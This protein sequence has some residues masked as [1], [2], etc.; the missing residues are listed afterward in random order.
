[1]NQEAQTR[2][3]VDMDGVLARFHDDILDENNVVQIEKMYEPN[4]FYQLKPFQKMVE[5][6]NHV[7]QY[8][9]NNIYILS[10]VD[11][12]HPDF[13]VQKTKWLQKYIP[14]LQ[15]S[16]FLFPDVKVDKCDFVKAMSS[17]HVLRKND[18]LIDDF[19][20]N[21]KSWH[22]AG[23]YSIKFKNNINH[24]G[25]GRFGGDKGEIWSGHIVYYDSPYL[26]DDI[27]VLLSSFFFE[28]FPYDPAYGFNLPDDEVMKIDTE[29]ENRMTAFAKTVN[30]IINRYGS[31]SISLDD[32]HCH[33]VV[34]KNL[35]FPDRKLYVVTTL[36]NLGAVGHEDFDSM[37]KLCLE[38]FTS[39]LFHNN[40]LVS[41]NIHLD[42]L[43][44][45]K[46]NHKD[47]DINDD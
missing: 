8:Y 12:A 45:I 38:F 37:E 22:E 32:Y 16:H 20:R 14:N 4:Y 5:V 17:N 11:N 19:N 41:P 47:K 44:K 25:Q 46:C 35:T 7:A 24:T 39:R 26:Y 31:C 33:Y 34:Y 28:K 29:I 40:F 21:L 42:K 30:D 6:I 23:G 43:A 27:Q 18:I 36:D 15:E 9:A 3:F 1:M 2:L 10:A 13:I